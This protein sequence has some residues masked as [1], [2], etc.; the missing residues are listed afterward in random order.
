MKI[1]H[2]LIVE[3]EIMVAMTLEMMVRTNKQMP[4]CR[5]ASSL[6]RKRIMGRSL[7]QADL[8]RPNP[9]SIE[10]L[11][12]STKKYL[13]RP[14]F[15]I[16]LNELLGGEVRHIAKAL[17]SREFDPTGAWSADRYIN[18]VGP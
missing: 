12:G 18:A 17:Q 14:E 10:L 8:Q 7:L 13:G 2:I 5:S 6:P 15:R 3:D 16:Q 1:L 4:R 9:R 11:V